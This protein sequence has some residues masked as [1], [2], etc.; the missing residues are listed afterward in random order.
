[1]GPN[2]AGDWT[3]ISLC[4]GEAAIL[5]LMQALKSRT[6]LGSSAINT[7][8]K[9]SD[10]LITETRGTSSLR[11]KCSETSHQNISQESSEHARPGIT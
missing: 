4:V 10:T 6:A 3:V 8:L 7:R 1:M 2:L 9:D 5:Y 11:I